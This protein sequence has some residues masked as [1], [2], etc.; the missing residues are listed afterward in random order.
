MSILGSKTKIDYHAKFEKVLRHKEGA[1]TEEEV[2][3]MKKE[4]EIM[5]EKILAAEKT[6][7]Y[8]NFF[9]KPALRLIHKSMSKV[10]T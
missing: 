4:E 3:T 8:N 7:V 6:K 2:E 9:N 10:A 1:L 5:K